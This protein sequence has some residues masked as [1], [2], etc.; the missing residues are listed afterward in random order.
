MS[1]IVSKT[2]NYVESPNDVKMAKTKQTPDEIPI[3]RIDKGLLLIL[4]IMISA[5]T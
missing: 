5:I 2:C 3:P 4:L 1:T